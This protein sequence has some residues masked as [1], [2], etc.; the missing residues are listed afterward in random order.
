MWIY[1]AGT[2]R[3][4]RNERTNEVQDN[5]VPPSLSTRSLSYPSSGPRSRFR[6][7]SALFLVLRVA[8]RDSELMLNVCFLSSLERVCETGLRELSPKDNRILGSRPKSRKAVSCCLF[9][10]CLKRHSERPVF[11]DRSWFILLCLFVVMSHCRYALWLTRD[12]TSFNV[13]VQVRTHELSNK[14]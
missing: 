8:L 10:G 9:P 3:N 2:E 4:A 11:L 5:G 14:H 6:L 7:C 1:Q 12:Y 13:M